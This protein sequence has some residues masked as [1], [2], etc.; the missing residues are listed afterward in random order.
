MDVD[1]S[2][3][4]GRAA[5][6]AHDSDMV[7]S[8][9][10]S[11]V[12]SWSLD[13]AA[14]RNRMAARSKDAVRRAQLAMQRMLL[15]GD[16]A[17]ASSADPAVAG[18]TRG[19]VI[20]PATF[21]LPAAV[22][23]APLRVADGETGTVWRPRPALALVAPS[24]PTLLAGG[25]A[26]VAT[27][28]AVTSA[29]AATVDDGF[30]VTDMDSSSGVGLP[31][32]PSRK[33]ANTHK[34][35]AAAV[36]AAA[37]SSLPVATPDAADDASSARYDDGVAAAG[38]LR[39]KL[40]SR[41]TDAAGSPSL[42][43]RI[44][45]PPAAAGAASS[46]LPSHVSPSLAALAA[47][48]PQLARR[49]PLSSSSSPGTHSATATVVASASAGYEMM[50]RSAMVRAAAAAARAAAAGVLSPASDAS[51]GSSP[52]VV[53]Q[54]L[55]AHAQ[56]YASA[57][58][59]GSGRPVLEP[60][61]SSGAPDVGAGVAAEPHESAVPHPLHPGVRA[62][63]TGDGE[64]L[65]PDATAAFM[66][67][68]VEPVG[69][70]A[71][72]PT[73]GIQSAASA[74]LAPAGFP[75]VPSPSTAAAAT[76]AILRAGGRGSLLPSPLSMS[77]FAVGGGSTAAII[78]GMAAGA[79]THRPSPLVPGRYHGS[80]PLAPRGAATGSSASA[81]AAAASAASSGGA[82]SSQT[83]TGKRTAAQAFGPND[84]HARW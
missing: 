72:A 78:A 74:L 84:P 34:L 66:R 81:V 23:S 68:G 5:G 54:R 76:S 65:F 18:S 79:R 42:P 67:R 40:R 6:T 2:A 4:A 50:A 7:Q 52:A 51:V 25:P 10:E 73:A 45:L 21:G 56:M 20:S 59:S 19:T 37:V 33:P 63:A 35:R 83:V 61:A 13:G 14:L 38:G 11:M 12:E 36:V 70:E 43:A 9:T 31:T 64:V 39:R 16:G 69:S 77:P 57:L 29:I 46:S 58:S 41:D 60:A 53:A 22:G 27:L 71:T 8:I 44:P 15:K 75:V 62:V 32:R 24:A 3:G 47:I 17:A 49:H 26:G 48:M 82:H 30:Q 28:S 55:A 1:A 80:S